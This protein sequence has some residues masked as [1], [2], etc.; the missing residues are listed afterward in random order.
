MF[1]KNY[2]GNLEIFMRH[3]LYEYRDSIDVNNLK[4]NPSIIV[5]PFVVLSKTEVFLNSIN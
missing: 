4:I 5:P 3:L 2:P 1:N